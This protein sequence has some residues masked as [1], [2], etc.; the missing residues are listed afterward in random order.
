M[1]GLSLLLISSVS[2]HAALSPIPEFLTLQGTWT[3]TKRVAELLAQLP[4]DLDVEQMVSRTLAVNKASA[5]YRVH[6]SAMSVGE[7]DEDISEGKSEV[8]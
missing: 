2:L 8:G 7:W 6:G 5:G 3:E 4:Q 1:V